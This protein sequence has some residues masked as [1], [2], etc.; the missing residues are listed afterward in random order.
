MKKKISGTRLEMAQ[1][2]PNMSKAKQ[3]LYDECVAQRDML[4]KHILYGAYFT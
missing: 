4:V 1:Q 3:Y 2:H